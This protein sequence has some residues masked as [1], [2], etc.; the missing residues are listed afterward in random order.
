MLDHRLARAEGARDGRCAALGDRE[1]RIDD[2]LAAVH[3]AGRDILALV[4]TGDT[5][6]PALHQA[7]LVINA[8]L[9]GQ[10][11]HG[12]G[13]DKA[14]ALDGLQRAG[15]F[16]RDH[17]AVQDGAGLLYG[18]DDV[19]GAQL[20]ADRGGRDEVPLLLAV[21]SRDVGAAGD[22]V[23][24]QGAHLGQGPLNAVVDVVE[25]AGSEFHGHG[26]AGG[27]NGGAGAE[28]GGLFIYLDGSSVAGHIQ[29][30]TDQAAVAHAHNVGYVGV[31]ETLRHDKRTGYLGNFTA[32]LSIFLSGSCC[33]GWL[34]AA[35]V[36]RRE[37]WCRRHA[38]P[39]LSGHSVQAPW[40]LRGRES[41]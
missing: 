21:Q 11:S 6:R 3:R 27:H 7:E 30:L 9:I 5:D 1:E 33:W 15:H 34:T 17:D 41:E 12:V 24:R 13:H 29:D 14:A 2:A 23:A 25:H 22:G 16:G 40:S 37:Y 28:A 39:P 36:S 20:I 38:P 35:A 8:L 26:H 19:A 31:R 18:A 4:G 32:H 10:N